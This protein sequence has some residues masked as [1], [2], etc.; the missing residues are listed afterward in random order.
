MDGMLYSVS[1]SKNLFCIDLNLFSAHAIDLPKIK[2]ASL[3]SII[4]VSMGHL[5]FA[6]CEYS[7]FSIWLLEDHNQ[8]DGWI[9]KYSISYDCLLFSLMVSPFQLHDDP[10][11]L[12]PY[13]IHPKSDVIFLGTAR[14][15]ISWH[16]KSNQFKL[17]YK[18]R[19][20]MVVPAGCYTPVLTSLVALSH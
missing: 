17:V 10:F 11:C 1:Y 16:I 8:A 9:L 6:Q 15:I 20:G 18:T 13:A 14:S 7:D 5:C 2:R 19:Y 4:G 12:Q 3:S